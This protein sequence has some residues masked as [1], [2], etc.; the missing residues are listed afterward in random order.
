MKPVKYIGMAAAGAILFG[1]SACDQRE[2]RVERAQGLGQAVLDQLAGKDLQ[3]D[4]TKPLDEYPLEARAMHGSIQPLSLPAIPDNA[5]RRYVIGS[6]VAKPKDVPPPIEVAAV[7][8]EPELIDYVAYNGQAESKT[9]VPDAEW[10]EQAE[11]QPELIDAIEQPTKSRSIKVVDPR[12]KKVARAVA[13]RSLGAQKETVVSREALRDS[14]QSKLPSRGLPSPTAPMAM[15]MPVELTAE[16]KMQALP[17]LEGKVATRALAMQNETLV[18]QVTAEDKMIDICSKYGWAASIQRSRTGQMVVE[19]GDDALRPTRFQGESAPRSV[20]GTETNISC[21]DYDWNSDMV[22]PEAAME[23]MIDELES[24]GEFEYVEKDYVFDHQLIRQPSG[25]P[26]ATVEITPNDPLF[27]R[28]WHYANQGSEEG[29]SPGGSGFVDFWTENDTQGSR[30]V[31]VAVVDTGLEM[32]HPDISGSENL[33]SGWDMV[34]DPLMGNDGDGRDANPNDAGDACPEKGVFEN[35]YHGTHVAGTVGAGLTNNGS[36][37]AGGA[38]NVKIVPVRALGRCGGRLSD[39]N[40]AI[41]WSA[42]TIPEFDAEG[43]EIWNENPADIINLSI[44]LFATCPASMQDAINAVTAEGVLVVSAAGN[45]RV[46]TDFYA[47]GGCDNVI[48]VAAGDARGHIAPYSNYGPA[49]DILAPGGDLSRDDNGDNNPD[50]VLSTKSADNCF[51]PV[52]G[53]AVET[54]HYAYEQGT[55]MAAPHVS[56]ALALMM[57]KRPDL[58]GSELVSRLLD[59]ATSIPDNQCA[60]PC[61]QYPGATPMDDNPEMCLRP[62]GGALLNLAGVDLSE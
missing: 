35:S 42:G 36:G 55:S 43:N 26:V 27:D 46:S 5:A 33:A 28:Q 47:P 39:I 2:E 30:E 4:Q 25:E 32:A 41:R 50:G 6:I 45:S 7:M 15:E 40:D 37:V 1:L 56:A 34:T 14:V 18:R 49:V 23:C 29:Q 13:T 17:Q 57:S 12:A 9:I 54:C 62:C 38:W 10:I 44:G 20:F 8:A 24:T 59:G 53:E 58:S 51:D 52:T 19:I 16:E 61:S 3:I 48:S 60:G 31:V 22:D 21:D 11:E